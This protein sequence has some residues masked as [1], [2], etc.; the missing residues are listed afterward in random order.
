MFSPGTEIA[1]VYPT[2]THVLQIDNSPRKTQE[3]YVHRVRD[4]I[5][6]PLTP[7][8]YLRRPYVARSRWLVLGSERIHDPPQSPPNRLQTASNSK[9]PANHAQKTKKGR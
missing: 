8:E 3:I 7:N 4:L 5:E 2:Q 1:L 6:Q 9:H